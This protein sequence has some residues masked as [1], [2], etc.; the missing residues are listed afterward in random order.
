MSKLSPEDASILA[1]AAE[2]PEM[3]DAMFDRLLDRVS[4]VRVKR[5]LRG[6]KSGRSRGNTDVRMAVQGLRLWAAR[7]REV[8]SSTGSKKNRK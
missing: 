8:H 4:S 7:N 3:S 1:L 6:L 5:I 2:H